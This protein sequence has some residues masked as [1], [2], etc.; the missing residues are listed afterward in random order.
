M[1]SLS[2]LNTAIVW[3]NHR[4]VKNKGASATVASGG[5]VVREAQ[6]YKSTAS[7]ADQQCNAQQVAEAP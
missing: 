5:S 3:I 6:L 2:L 7:I 4:F 1:S